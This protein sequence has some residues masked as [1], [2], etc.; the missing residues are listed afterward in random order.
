VVSSILL[1][2]AQHR[3]KG[4]ADVPVRPHGAAFRWRRNKGGRRDFQRPGAADGFTVQRCCGWPCPLRGDRPMIH[5]GAAGARRAL[6]SITRQG[7]GWIAPGP[8]RIA[9]WDDQRGHI[10]TID[11]A[12]MDQAHQGRPLWLHILQFPLIRL[13]VL[14]AG[15]LSLMAWTETRILAFDDSPL[16]GVAIAVVMALVVMAVYVAWA[17]LVERREVTELSL[18][19]AGREWAIGALIGAGLYAGCVMLLMLLG[20]YRIEGLNPVAFMISAASMAVKSSVFEEL[21]F[22]GVLFRSVEEMAG[23]WIAIIV[24]SLVFG[25]IHLV[26]PGATIAGAVYIAI[27][28]GLLLAAAYLVTR[29]LWIAIGFHMLWNYVQSAVFSGIV[30]GAVATPGLF[31]ARIEGPGFFTG[32]SFGME[33]SVFALILCTAAGV[34]MLTVA[35]RRGHLV[36]AP[37][38]RRG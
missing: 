14:G 25:L 3:P 18:P 1:L 8:I 10:T 5:R 22:R 31:R 16:I 6:A 27:E 4:S 11:G 37:W 21:A 19:G 12:I 7:S 26:N 17:R 9:Q 28:A 23:S 13:I 30:S 33:Q 36:P 2:L 32:G 15:V 24:S 38:N 34:V 20:M 35:I 29:R